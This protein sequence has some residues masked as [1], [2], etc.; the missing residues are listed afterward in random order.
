MKC[1]KVITIYIAHSVVDTG[2]LFVSTAKTM[3]ETIIVSCFTEPTLI[4]RCRIFRC[5]NVLY[6]FLFY[7]RDDGCKPCYLRIL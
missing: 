3:D 5:V 6:Y 4:L 7:F 1:M 2:S